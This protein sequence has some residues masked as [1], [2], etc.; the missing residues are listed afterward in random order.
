MLGLLA[1]GAAPDV[2]SVDELGIIGTRKQILS[3]LTIQEATRRWLTTR[4]GAA[5]GMQ[6]SSNDAA[7]DGDLN[8]NMAIN[9]DTGCAISMAALQQVYDK[10]CTPGT[11]AFEQRWQQ[12]HSAVFDVTRLSTYSDPEV[13]PSSRVSSGAPAAEVPHAAAAAAWEHVLPAAVRQVLGNL[14]GADGPLTSVRSAVTAALRPSG[15]DKSAPTG[16]LGGNHGVGEATAAPPRTMRA[17]RKQMHQREANTP[18]MCGPLL[19][20]GQ[21]LGHWKLRY[22]IL[23]VDGELTC[24]RRKTD[25]DESKP[26]MYNTQ[27]AELRVTMLPPERLEAEASTSGVFG[28]RLD[29]ARGCRDLFAETQEDWGRWIGAFALLGACAGAAVAATDNAAGSGSAGA[30]TLDRR[31]PRLAAAAAQPA[32]RMT[33]P[34]PRE[35]SADASDLCVLDLCGFKLS[36]SEAEAYCTWCSQRAKEVKRHAKQHERWS[37]L[38]REYE[39]GSHRVSSDASAAEGASATEAAA[40]S[41]QGEGWTRPASPQT[42]PRTG[43]SFRE[44]RASDESG[45]SDDAMTPPPFARSTTEPRLTRRGSFSKLLLTPSPAADNN[46]DSSTRSDTN[47]TLVKAVHDLAVGGV[48]NGL[49]VRVWS[50]LSG[51]ATL[52]ASYPTHYKDMLAVG[53]QMDEHDRNEVEID[54]GR[55]FPDHPLFAG[56]HIL[57]DAD[58]MAVSS[59]RGGDVALQTDAPAPGPVPPSADSRPPEEQGAARIGPSTGQPAAAP[60]PAGEPRGRTALRRVLL[61]YVAHSRGLGYCQA[62]NYVGGMLLLLTEMREELA[63]FLL[64]HLADRCVV[65]FYSKYMNGIRLEQRVF[66]DYFRATLPTLAAHLDRSGLPLSIVTTNWFMCLYVNTLPAETLLRVWD[67]VLLEEP[68]VLVRVGVA[69]LRLHEDELLET[70]DFIELS[71]KLQQLGRGAWS[72]DT[73]LTVAYKQLGNTPGARKVLASLHNLH[74]VAKSVGCPL[75]DAVREVRLREGLIDANGGTTPASPSASEDNGALPTVGGSAGGIAAPVVAEES[76]LAAC[77]PDDTETDSPSSPTVD[78][79]AMR[80]QRRVSRMELSGRRVFAASFTSSP[81]SG[82]ST[83]QESRMNLVRPRY[84]L[85]RSRR[86]QRLSTANSSSASSEMMVQRRSS[87]DSFDEG[88]DEDEDEEDDDGD[89]EYDIRGELGSPPSKAP[90]TQAEEELHA[91]VE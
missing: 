21:R 29:S 83:A 85:Q 27:L 38:L 57:P 81:S 22:Y 45:Q 8:T 49:R 65:D 55:T 51:V 89:D 78:A 70:S 32:L 48:P 47:P 53:E 6:R 23:T 14:G 82:G 91:Q 37:K 64:I 68:T 15:D 34:S 66:E 24:Y 77:T 67:L 13:V 62:L 52:M 7:D 5:H 9:L 76:N 59:P 25:L 40:P 35:S 41:P 73:L 1:S 33:F 39:A 69:L 3:A 4:G 61:A 87:D 60:A 31:S 19:K 28:F 44:G 18:L 12:Q 71:T 84:D 50:Q 88:R 58:R 74:H 80:P 75:V 2:R 30:N 26:P 43:G 63:F 79:A 11:S 56:D 16:S 36:G 17:R 72:A 42:P 86:S 46:G 10:G 54:L 90:L 20:R